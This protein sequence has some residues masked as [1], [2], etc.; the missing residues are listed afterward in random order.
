[1]YYREDKIMMSLGFVLFVLMV[2]GALASF[3]LERI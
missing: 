1:M 3:V 2:L